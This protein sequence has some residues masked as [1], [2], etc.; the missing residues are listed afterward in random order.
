MKIRVISR[1]DLK[2]LISIRDIV[3]VVEESFKEFSLGHTQA[4]PRYKMSIN[5]SHAG[6]TVGSA[7]VGETVDGFATKI[8]G[9]NYEN[10]AKRNIPSLLGVVVVN[11]PYTGGFK[12]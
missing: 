7:F 9:V 8:V 4:P 10:P 3:D 11:D 5:E 1:E 12:L 6:F 2:N